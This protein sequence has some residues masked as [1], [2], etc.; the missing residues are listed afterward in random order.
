LRVGRHS[1]QQKEGNRKRKKRYLKKTCHEGE[2]LDKL[3]GIWH[4]LHEAKE[5]SIEGEKYTG[6]RVR[7]REGQ[8]L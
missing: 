1:E 5:T 3:L 8:R 2:R 7:E 4:N 6:S